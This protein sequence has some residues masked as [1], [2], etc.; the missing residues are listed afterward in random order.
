[1]D[2]TLFIYMKQNEH[3][4]SEKIAL[5]F[6]IFIIH[7]LPKVKQVSVTDCSSHFL[8]LKIGMPVCFTGDSC[9]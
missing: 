6:I 5:T 7:I 4:K 8:Y 3:F 9:F 2:Q 1:M